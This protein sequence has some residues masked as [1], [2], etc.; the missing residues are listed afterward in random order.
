MRLGEHMQEATSIIGLAATEPC[1]TRPVRTAVIGVGHQGRRHAQKFAALGQSELRGV[2]D[3]DR[4]RSRNVAA[5]HDVESIDDIASL[6]GVVDAAIVA[7]PTPTH[8]EIVTRLL[9]SGI[10]V[11]VEK[12]IATTVEEARDLVELAE[13]KDLVFQVGH[14]ERFNPAVVAMARK[15][16]CP[17]FIESNRIAPFKSRGV[18]VSVVLDLMIHDIELI[19]SFVQSPIVDLDT[20]GRPVFSRHIDVANARLR[21]ENGCVADVTSSRIS[22]KTERSLR[23]FQPESYLSADM[24]NRTFTFYD[25]KY[26]G[27]VRGPDDVAVEMQSFANGDALMEQSKSFLEAVAGGPPPIVSGRTAMQALETAARIGDMVAEQVT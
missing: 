22:L 2:V 23:I 17:V 9:Q 13:A 10:H 26:D 12:P 3:I 16:K 25:K 5:E 15:I 6:A 8:H 4:Q 7:T 18:D 11:L 19:H 1:S 21:F 14:V 20:V 24:H 27:E